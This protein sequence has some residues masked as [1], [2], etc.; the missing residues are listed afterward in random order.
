MNSN[1]LIK[2]SYTIHTLI[3]VTRLRFPYST[4]N[5]ASVFFQFGEGQDLIEDGIQIEATN[6]F[7]VMFS[8]LRL[9]DQVIESVYEST[10]K[11]RSA[12]T[13]SF[14]NFSPDS[15]RVFKPTRCILSIDKGWRPHTEVF[16]VYF[17]QAIVFVYL[18]VLELI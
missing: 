15:M 12:A 7:H 2:Q 5:Y 8:R 3:L 17:L 11:D 1:P 6:Y 13:G 4:L 9:C 16:P 14:I 10:S 18:L